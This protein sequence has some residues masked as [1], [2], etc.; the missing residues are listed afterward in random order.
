MK[1]SMITLVIMLAVLALLVTTAFS[2][3]NL[4]FL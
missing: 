4:G 3:L 1:K 2:G